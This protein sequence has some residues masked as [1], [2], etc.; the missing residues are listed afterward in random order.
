M[1][2][3]GEVNVAV[4]LVTAATVMLSTKKVRNNACGLRTCRITRQVVVRAAGVVKVTGSER[5]DRLPM[6]SN[7]TTTTVYV[8]RCEPAP[9]LLGFVL[10][11]LLEENLRRALIISRGD[12]SVF[13]TRPIS[14]VLLTVA[15]AA[16]VVAALPTIRKRREVVFAEEE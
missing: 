9:L 11:P 3:A 7:A 14:A 8:V 16:L 5:G 13:L 12:A 2:A 15:V 4:Q 6:G 1:C 10:G